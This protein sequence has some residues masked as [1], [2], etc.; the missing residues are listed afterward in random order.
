[1]RVKTNNVHRFCGIFLK[2]WTDIINIIIYL[3]I[4]IMIIII[5]IIIITHQS[6]NLPTL[7]VTTIFQ[8]DNQRRC[9]ARIATATTTTICS[10]LT[11]LRFCI[12][13]LSCASSE[14]LNMLMNF[15]NYD[16]EPP[17][18]S[19]FKTPFVG[20]KFNDRWMQIF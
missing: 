6:L 11:R 20:A 5:V 19:Y 9:S 14:I 2:K 7:S 13:F 1:M 8:S 4:V 3:I 12:T 10:H 16:K 15:I 17:I 18:A